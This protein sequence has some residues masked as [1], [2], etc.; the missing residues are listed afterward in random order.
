MRKILAAAVLSVSVLAILLIHSCHKGIGD[1]YAEPITII[2][3]DSLT[4]TY[5]AAGTVQ[6][7]QI[8]FTTDR[9][10]LWA[11]CM[12]E[13][14]S[15]NATNTTYTYPDTLFYTILDS[16]AAK[17]NNKYTYTGSYL[18]PDSAAALTTIRF[19]VQFK[20]ALNPSSVDT[21]FYD[22]Q[23]KMVVR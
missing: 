3:P 9:P 13:V 14:D 4:V 22:K 12:Y 10:I 23:F 7:V 15:P 2:Q 8:Q 1:S 6:P 18:V 11:K 19:D 20:A 17:L 21:V 16:V 5:V